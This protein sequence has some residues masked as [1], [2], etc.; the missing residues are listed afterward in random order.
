MPMIQQ[1]VQDMTGKAPNKSVNPTGGIA[2]R[3]QAG[4]LWATREAPVVDVTP[5]GLETMGAVMPRDPRNDHS[6]A[7]EEIFARPKPD[8]RRYS[9]P[10]RYYGHDNKTLGRFRWTA[11]LAPRGVPW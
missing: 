5:A 8:R 9:R 7:Q 11:F 10:G 3:R 1:L 4:V 6:D 2:G